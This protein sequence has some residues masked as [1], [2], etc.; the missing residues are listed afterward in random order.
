[1]MLV[2][3]PLNDLSNIASD[4]KYRSRDGTWKT[5]GLDGSWESDALIVMNHA[6]GMSVNWH[7][8]QNEWIAVYNAP[9]GNQILM[10]TATSPQG[11]QASQ[12]SLTWSPP[13]SISPIPEMIQGD[14]RYVPGNFCYAAI[15][16]IEWAT[17]NSMLVTYD[18]NN[19]N[20]TTVLNYMELYH[21]VPVTITLP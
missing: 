18:C 17:A 14:P 11:A 1:M 7:G 19:G 15:E 3:A 12:D 20:S 10:R 8:A 4:L 21:P 13:Q 6:S 16:H 9:F 5:P 2:R